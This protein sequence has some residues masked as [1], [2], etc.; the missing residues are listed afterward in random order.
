[1]FYGS[2]IEKIEINDNINTVSNY[3]FSTCKT[4]KKVW[5]S[6]QVDT[7]SASNASYSPFKGCTDANLI[8]YTDAT[9]KPSGWSDYWNYI[10]SSKQVPV[11]W[12]ATKENYENGD[13]PPES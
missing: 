11:Y 8:I 10:D 13:L 7:I 5:I 4:L 2:G 3:A 12:G 1:M 9:E 6:S